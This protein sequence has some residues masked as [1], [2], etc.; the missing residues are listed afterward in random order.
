[1]IFNDFLFRSGVL[2][3]SAVALALH[4]L[5]YQPI[6]VRVD[7]GDLA[8]LSRQVYEIFS[9]ISQKYNQGWFKEL[10][11]VASNDIN[12]ETII[13]LNDQGHCINTFA[14]G[15][16]L[17]TCQKQPALGCVYKVTRCVKTF[18]KLFEAFKAWLILSSHC[19][20]FIIVANGSQWR[21]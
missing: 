20:C 14:I 19:F 11:I 12:E 3:F 2:N 21:A 16:H 13:S 10:Q 8:Y 1:M 18:P 7:S 6:G 5:N 15:T 17:V 4:E 9:I